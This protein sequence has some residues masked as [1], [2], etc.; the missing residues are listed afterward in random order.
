TGIDIAQ[1]TRIKLA[2]L[3]IGLGFNGEVPYP[4][5]STKEKAQKFIGLPMDKLK[6]DK[7]KFKKEL[8]PQWLKEAKERER[9]YTTENL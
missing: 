6:E 7:A 5:I 3:L 9:K 2:R 8:L 4:D 1:E